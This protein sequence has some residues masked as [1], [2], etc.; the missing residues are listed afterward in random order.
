MIKHDMIYFLAMLLFLVLPILSAMKWGDPIA[1]RLDRRRLRRRG[2]RRNRISLPETLK[3]PD[4]LLTHI[5]EAEE[6]SEKV[7]LRI[8]ERL[9]DLKRLTINA[10]K[11]RRNGT[12]RDIISP[13]EMLESLTIRKEASLNFILDIACLQ[14]DRID[15]MVLE[16]DAL[17]KAADW[18]PELLSSGKGP[19]DPVAGALSGQSYTPA[20]ER[21][22]K[23]VQDANKKRRTI[24][25]RLKEI[26][27]WK[28]PDR[29]PQPQSPPHEPDGGIKGTRYDV[30]LQ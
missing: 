21:L 15:A 19:P 4:E 8:G 22:L 23:R 29:N 27:S 25:D 16:V 9:L 7:D 2:I 20:A 28:P 5:K 30:T 18:S 6:R 11:L 12:A 17:S 1:D 13:S 14:S 24:D 26:K 10:Y 3:G